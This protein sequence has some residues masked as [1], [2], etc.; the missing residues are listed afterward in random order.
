MPTAWGYVVIWL[1]P[2]CIHTWQL[3]QRAQAKVCGWN[4]LHQALG[5]LG[6]PSWHDRAQEKAPNMMQR[7]FGTLVCKH[8]RYPM[9]VKKA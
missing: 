9:K 3:H 7:R 8:F 6:H 1:R 5:K 2:P 4:N